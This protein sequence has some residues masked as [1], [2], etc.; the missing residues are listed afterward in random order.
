MQATNL[1]QQ[2]LVISKGN[3]QAIA[4]M[5]KNSEAVLSST[6]NWISRGDLSRAQRY[7]AGADNLRV[8]GALS[9]AQLQ[10]LNKPA[11]CINYL[12]R[13]VLAL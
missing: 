1:Y 8:A 10:E 12:L 4:C 3:K 11:S 2:A 9:G 6:S 5:R 7:L 13:R